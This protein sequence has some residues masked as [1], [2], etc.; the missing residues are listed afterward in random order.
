MIK[1][2]H[3]AARLTCDASSTSPLKI[4]TGQVPYLKPAALEF[5]KPLS[6]PGQMCLYH[7][8]VASQSGGQAGIITDIAIQNPTSTTMTF[9]S[10]S[11]VVIGVDK[12]MPGTE[13]AAGDTNMTSSK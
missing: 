5:V 13:M 4:L 1:N 3:I 12:I 2:G 9:P 8:D 11:T 6:T 10:T 7:V